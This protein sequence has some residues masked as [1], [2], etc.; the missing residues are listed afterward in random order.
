MVL[1]I[2]GMVVLATGYKAHILTWTVIKEKNYFLEF[3]PTPLLDEKGNIIGVLETIKDRTG[4][5]LAL[6]AIRDQ[7]K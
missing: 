3:E 6:Q 4:Q 2:A 5:K 7:G 1:D